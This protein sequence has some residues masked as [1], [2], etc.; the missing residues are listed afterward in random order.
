MKLLVAVRSMKIKHIAF[1]LISLVLLLLT[2]ITSAQQLRGCV[3]L[4]GQYVEIGIA[5][6]GAFGTPTNAPHGYHGRPTPLIASLY[7]P[8]DSTYKP[9]DSAVGFVADHGKDG[10]DVGA[11]G[12]PGYFGDYFITHK[13]E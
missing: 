3:F 12:L 1:A 5:P 2:N 9:R 13:S 10:W 7:N 4:Q 11:G 6:N 8:F